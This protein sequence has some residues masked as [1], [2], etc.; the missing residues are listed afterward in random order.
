VSCELELKILFSRKSRQSRQ[1]FRA[2]LREIREIITL[3]FSS[4]AA[5]NVPTLSPLITH[6]SSLTAQNVLLFFCRKISQLATHCSSLKAHNSL[7][8]IASTVYRTT[9]LLS[10]N[11]KGALS[12]GHSEKKRY[13]C[14]RNL[15]NTAHEKVIFIK[16]KQT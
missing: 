12:L 1:R 8:K 5:R 14:K 3:V 7:L 10:D 11:Q 6:F 9:N 16:Q 2:I 13:F 4:D 15:I